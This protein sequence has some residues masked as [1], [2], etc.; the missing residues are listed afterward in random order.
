MSLRV[1]PVFSVV[2]VA[3][4]GAM[5]KTSM[6]EDPFRQCLLSNSH[7]SLGYCLGVG[8]MS[9]LERVDADAEFDMVDGL[10]F[11][12]DENKELREGV[13]FIERDPADFRFV[14]LILRPFL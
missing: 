5:V 9:K 13:N 1:A 11:E 8:A 10:T 14:N 2:L 4:V 6:T 3:V 7:G 12:R